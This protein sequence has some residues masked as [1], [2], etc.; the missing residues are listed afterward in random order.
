VD[1]EKILDHYYDE[2]K[3]VTREQEEKMANIK[4]KR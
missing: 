4:W 2:C 1:L 3:G